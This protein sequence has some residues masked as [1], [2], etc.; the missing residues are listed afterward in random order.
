MKW[1]QGRCEQTSALKKLTLKVGKS[2]DAYIISM[3]T[4][5]TIGEHLDTVGE[6][7]NHYRLNITLKGKW[8]LGLHSRQIPQRVGSFHLFRPDIQPH[9]AAVQSKTYILSIGWVTRKKL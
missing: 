4:G 5:A 3:P 9:S 7:K 8:S 6:D 2:Y 1:T